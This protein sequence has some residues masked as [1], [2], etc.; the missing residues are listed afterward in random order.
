MVNY[1]D[2]A[3]IQ[4]EGARADAL[5]QLADNGVQLAW[6]PY[7][8]R[9]GALFEL[10]TTSLQPLAVDRLVQGAEDSADS[11]PFGMR[12]MQLAPDDALPSVPIPAYARAASGFH[13]A[14]EIK[15]DGS[16]SGKLVLLRFVVQSTLPGLK[17]P[18]WSE[19]RRFLP[20]NG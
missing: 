7:G 6:D 19:I 5:Q 11:R 17:R 13:G 8:R 3:S 16:T 1:F 4:D 18:I 10:A 9:S 14:F 15:V 12:N 2:V 20:T